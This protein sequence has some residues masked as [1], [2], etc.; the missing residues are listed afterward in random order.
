M[1][2]MIFIFYL[3]FL[4]TIEII[5]RKVKEFFKSETQMN[6]INEF[7]NKL[8]LLL[9][10]IFDKKNNKIETINKSTSEMTKDEL[11]KELNES[12]RYSMRPKQWIGGGIGVF[13]YFIAKTIG[14]YGWHGGDIIGVFLLAFLP[15]AIFIGGWLEGNY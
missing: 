9:K 5:I 12:K 1:G 3:F 2:F 13:L 14:G 4:L 6:K 15:G 8:K 11:I 10:N 7:I